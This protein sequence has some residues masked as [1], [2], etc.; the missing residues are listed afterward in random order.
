MKK[1]EQVL[2]IML[3]EE[4]KKHVKTYLDVR[5]SSKKLMLYSDDQRIDQIMFQLLSNAAKFTEKGSIHF[6]YSLTGDKVQLFVRDTGIGIEEKEI[7]HIFERFNQVDN[8][9]ARQYEGAG[10][11]LTIVHGLVHLLKGQLEVKSTPGKGSEFIIYIPT[12]YTSK[13]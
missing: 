4:N 3:D 10:L 13:N 7:P 9:L 6:G 12:N 2:R 5:E 8:T 11:G 1:Q